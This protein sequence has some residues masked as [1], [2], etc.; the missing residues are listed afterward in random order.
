MC[1]CRARL[2]C[3]A[4]HADA[5]ERIERGRRAQAPRISP[6][7]SVRLRSHAAIMHQIHYH[8]HA[9]GNVDAPVPHVYKRPRDELGHILCV[10]ERGRETLLELL[11]TLLADENENE[12]NEEDWVPVLSPETENSDLDADA[13]HTLALALVVLLRTDNAVLR[14]GAEATAGCASRST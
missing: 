1:Y 5:N 10:C 8:V 7:V 12:V 4:V 13:T 6:G 2:T 11:H 14:T 9:P 3:F